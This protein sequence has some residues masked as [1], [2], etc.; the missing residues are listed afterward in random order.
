MLPDMRDLRGDDRAQAEIV[1]LILVI[2][3]IVLIIYGAT[4]ATGTEVGSGLEWIGIG[5]IIADVGGFVVVKTPTVLIGGG[6]GFVIL[7]IGAFI[8]LATGH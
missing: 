1:A 7:L 3:G 2:I 4:L 6:A 5:I 8:H